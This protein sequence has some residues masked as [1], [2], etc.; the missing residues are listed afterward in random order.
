MA[1]ATIPAVVGAAASQ[2]SRK[3]K[4][5]GQLGWWGRLTGVWSVSRVLVVLII[6]LG[7]GVFTYPEVANWV[8]EISHSSEV[9]SY[10]AQVAQMPPE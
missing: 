1:T 9:Q 5:Q 6:T 7:V 8:S 10:A 2:R 4:R 3:T